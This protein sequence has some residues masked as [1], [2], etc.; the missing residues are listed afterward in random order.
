MGA[1][2]RWS[3]LSGL[4]IDKV[5]DIGAYNITLRFKLLSSSELCTSDTKVHDE[6]VE[7]S[8]LNSGSPGSKCP[9]IKP[10]SLT[11]YS[12]RITQSL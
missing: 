3:F 5:Y 10:A 4:S 8:V 6:F 12:Q 2:D 9:T 11:R 1:A 7:N